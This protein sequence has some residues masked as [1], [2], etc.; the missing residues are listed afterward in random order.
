M[1]KK[2]RRRGGKGKKRNSSVLSWVALAGVVAVAIALGVV[3]VRTI[4]NVPQYDEATLCPVE[5]PTS[6]L[7]VLLDLTDPVS[8][9]Q[10]RTLNR[11]LEQRIDATPAGT[12]ISVG[13]VSENPDEW[14][15]QF[16]R[17]KPEMGENANVIYQNPGLI[18]EQ[19]EMG[20][21]LPLRSALD[22][23]LDSEEQSQSPIVEAL[24][25]L[26]EDTLV[27]TPGNAPSQL[28]IVSD[29]IQNS[30]RVSFYA[31]QG[32]DHF[33]VGGE[34]LSRN[35]T[36]TNIVLV[37]ISRSGANACV[38]EEL[39]PFWARYLDEKGAS[40]PFEIERLGDL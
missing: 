1:S 36:G 16:T 5:G 3:V 6:S 7:V 27:M 21:R 14:G 25:R 26:V 10:A 13:V 29:M 20:F 2:R 28:I 31:C 17:C 37:R 32:W 4:M 35:L 15:A 39:E 18:A 22:E 40:A 12:L 34:P 24:H 19:F 9:T 38:A 30:D 11:I 23:M 33:R 8:E